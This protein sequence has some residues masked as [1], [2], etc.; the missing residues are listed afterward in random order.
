V[1]TCG[2]PGGDQSLQL[3]RN[4]G[5]RFSPTTQFGHLTSLIPFD[6]VP[7]PYGIQTDMVATGGSSDFAIV[8]TKDGG[9][10]GI[11]QR[12]FGADVRA[13]RKT[14]FRE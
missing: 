5:M 12:V 8:D 4:K 9:V 13:N 14:G 3:S 1:C 11:T 6:G 2:F 10:I 7:N